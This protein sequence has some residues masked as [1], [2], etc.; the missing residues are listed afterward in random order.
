MPAH[1]K[2]TCSVGTPIQHASISEVPCTEWHRPTCGR[3][4]PASIAQQFAAMAGDEAYRDLSVRVSEEF[5]DSDWEAMQ[6][7]EE[8]RK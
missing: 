4:L 8:V 3:P 7:T 1:K 6:L 2:F 5:S